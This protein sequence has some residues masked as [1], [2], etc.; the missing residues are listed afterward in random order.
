MKKK[1]VYSCSGCSSAAQMANWI[2]IQLDRMGLA[3][4]S[5]IAGIG[6]CVAPLIKKAA[7][8]DFLIAIDGCPLACARHCLDREGLRSAVHYDLS[9]MGA[10]KILHSDFDLKEARKI[11]RLIVEDLRNKNICA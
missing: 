5:C 3:E 6:G 2:A 4:M 11:L 8:A 7:A 9:Q 1:L 10:K